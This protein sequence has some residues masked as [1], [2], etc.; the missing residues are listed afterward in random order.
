ML[1]T[2]VDVATGKG[3]T[4]PAAERRMS[5]RRP[6]RQRG[7]GMF[8]VCLGLVLGM[9]DESGRKRWRRG[10]EVAIQGEPMAV[11]V[12]ASWQWISR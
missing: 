12:V 2:A 3:V 6:G 4:A 11:V 9:E 7:F 1:D 5:E 8:D 10:E